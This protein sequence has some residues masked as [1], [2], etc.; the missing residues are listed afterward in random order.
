[1]PIHIPHLIEPFQG[2]DE[3]WQAYFNQQHAGLRYSIAYSETIGLFALFSI[4]KNRA[5]KAARE[6]YHAKVK[7]YNE[8]M[9][10]V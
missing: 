9:G 4:K 5:L 2:S 1:M 6:D 3:Q 7:L 10:V 8:L